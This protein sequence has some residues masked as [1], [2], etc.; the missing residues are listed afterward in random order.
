MPDNRRPDGA[1]ALS[2]TAPGQARPT[3]RTLLSQSTS[4]MAGLT[5]YLVQHGTSVV[6]GNVLVQQ[7]GIPIPAEPT[8]V[9]AG[10]LAA[11]GLLSGGRVV[12]ATVVA[13]VM[14]D[15]AWF[16]LGR[17]YGHALL[18]AMARLSI[19][20]GDARSEARFARWGLRSLLLARFVPGATQLLVPLAGARRVAPVAFLFYDFTGIVV[21][22]SVPVVGG[23]LL[24]RQADALFHAVS[25]GAMWLMLAPAVVVA[26]KV[27]RF[28]HPTKQPGRAAL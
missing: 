28:R 24:G 27:W 26:V 14:A 3:A 1:A 7:L 25:V 16:F 17:R 6:F 4:I 10:S 19:T 13:T 9:L 8:L 2:R 5:D 20:R 22:A 12:V 21:W 18:K 15:A 11:R 23:M